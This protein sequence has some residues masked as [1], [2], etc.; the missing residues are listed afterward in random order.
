MVFD[1]KKVIV[2]DVPLFS[3]SYKNFLTYTY[4]FLDAFADE[5]DVG[6]VGQI[7]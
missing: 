7:K 5:E 3:L 2:V 6:A 4:G 1:V